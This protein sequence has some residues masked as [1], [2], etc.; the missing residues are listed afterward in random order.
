MIL[1][2]TNLNQSSGKMVVYVSVRVSVSACGVC[3]WVYVRGSRPDGEVDESHSS[4]PT[5]T[6]REQ[7]QFS[8]V[9]I[10]KSILTSPCL[11]RQ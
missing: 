6:T 11:L 3:V 1:M 8:V 4:P 9:N 10:I 5:P 7:Q 2:Q